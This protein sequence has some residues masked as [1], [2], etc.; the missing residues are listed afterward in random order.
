MSDLLAGIVEVMAGA[1]LVTD[2]EGRFVRANAA[3][4]Q[5]LGIERGRIV[6]ASYVSTPW[7]RLRLDGAPLPPDDHPF[8][9]VRRTGRPVLDVQFQIERDDG[10]RITISVNAAPLWEGAAF[11]GIV[12]IFTDVSERRRT[13]ERLRALTEE[14]EREVQFRTAELLAENAERRRVQE[15]QAALLAENR[16]L[17]QALERQLEQVRRARRLVVEADEQLRKDIAE[18]LHGAVQTRLLVAWHRLG[19]VRTLLGTDPEAAAGVLDTVRDELDRI[20]EHDVRE[21]SHLLHPSII[22]VGLVPAVRSLAA[23]LGGPLELIVDVTEEIR[24]LD[25]PAGNAIAEPLRLAAYRI[26]EEALSN[27][28]RHAG[29]S[30]A[31]IRLA[32]EGAALLVEVEDNGQ[33]LDGGGQ[34]GVG[35]ASIAARVDQFG[36]DWSLSGVPS[37]GVLLRV[38]LPLRQ[39]GVDGD[40]RAGAG[41]A[42]GEQRGQG[43]G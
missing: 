35:L 31:T 3:A 27:I 13:E 23:R 12:A 30:C 2:A 19:Q 40:H 8:V 33:G 32:T 38:R 29:A 25:D 36:G 7:R 26:L 24:R 14:L 5:M 1:L 41:A 18:R 9:T 20:R 16:R 39:S 4:E 11:A 43:I 17:V 22:R 34:P 42:S 6:G 28:Y 10:S 15:A 21:A 37:G